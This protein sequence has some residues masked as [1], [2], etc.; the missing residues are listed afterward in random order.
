MQKKSLFSIN[1]FWESLK[2]S[3]HVM[4][5]HTIALLF[6]T[7]LPAYMTWWEYRGRTSTWG[8]TYKIAEYL[9]GFYDFMLFV[10]I[11]AVV[12]TVWSNFSYLFK[13]GSMKFYNALPYTRSCIYISKFAAALVSAIVPA[14]CVLA[15]NAC[16]YFN[17]YISC[18]EEVNVFSLMGAVV[19][20]YLT[21]LSVCV[22]AASVAGNVIAML[23]TAGFSVLWYVAG[24]IALMVY[25]ESGIQGIDISISDN[26][27]CF[28]PPFIMAFSNVYT[29]ITAEWVMLAGVYI[30]GFF[31][32]GIVCCNMRKSENTEKF[33][34]FDRMASFFKYYISIVAALIY[35]TLFG[36]MVGN[37][38]LSTVAYAVV[39]VLMYC[40]LQAIF[41]KNVRSLFEQMRKVL[42]VS[43]CLA[44]IL[45]PGICGLIKIDTINPIMYTELEVRCDKFEVILAE[46]ANVS[47]TAKVYN[48]EEKGTDRMF[49]AAKSI[50]P[51]VNI[52][53][54]RYDVAQ[55]EYEKYMNYII[56]CD[57]YA[58]R[59]ID[60]AKEVGVRLFAGDGQV[61]SVNLYAGGSTVTRRFYDVLKSDML[62]YDYNAEKDSG[63]YAMLQMQIEG[64]TFTERYFNA[65]RIYNCYEDT[66]KWLEDNTTFYNIKW[67]NLKIESWT[68][69]YSL[70]YETDDGDIIEKIIKCCGLNEHMKDGE[71]FVS[72]DGKMMAV[73][74][75]GFS[76]EVKEIIKPEC[77]SDAP[78]L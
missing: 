31:A 30:V 59:I 66:V 64:K 49:V 16:M 39:F 70:V 25:T 8:E 65:V 12:M 45:L 35:G 40:I 62:K 51:L 67:N 73:N 20:C 47:I 42:I 4:I 17:M 1:I 55:E 41:E 75:E 27:E 53:W 7:T 63:V 10:I 78:V 58:E 15:V 77:H 5:V 69:G 2:R 54:R 76:K 56:S 18:M 74:Y 37:V 3:R 22:F 9:T 60:R 72:I 19:L 43:A 26:I 36:Y 61:H 48:S 14:I 11:G 44:A 52:T 57:E 71:L 46:R 68:D 21:V 34:V 29:E 38:L 50:L 6:A 23:F 28:F 33:I 24:L 13:S 32:L